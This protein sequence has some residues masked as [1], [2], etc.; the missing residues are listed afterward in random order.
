MKAD[1]APSADQVML[2]S[3]KAKQAHES[4]LRRQNKKKEPEKV[5]SRRQ[6]KK[7]ALKQNTFGFMQD[8]NQRGIFDNSSRN[9][10]EGE[11]LDVPAY[12]RRGVKISL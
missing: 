7:D 5:K 10:Y 8:N 11:D 1:V 4:K 9:M 12:L 2:D 3:T 6:A